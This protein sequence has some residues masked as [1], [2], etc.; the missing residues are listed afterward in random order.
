MLALNLLISFAILLQVIALAIS[1]RLMRITK[2][3][4][5]WILFSVAFLLMLVQLISELVGNFRGRGW[6]DP[7][8]I[9][10]IWLLTTMC[11][12]S[13]LF[14][15]NKLIK[16]IIVM[17][18]KRSLSQR[19]ILNT[20]IKT[21]EKERRRFS[22]DLHDG[23]GPLLSS[24]KL[25]ISALDSSIVTAQNRAIL[26]SAGEVI[27]EAIKSLKEISNNLNP[28]VLNNFGVSRA[29][30]SFI[31]KLVLPSQIKISFTSDL[32]NER[33]DSGI[34]AIIYRVV[35]EL[36]NNSIKH[37][38]A[39]KIVVDLKSNGGSIEIAV[40]DNGVGFDREILDKGEAR[41]GMGLSSIISRIS[42]VKGDIL[43]DTAIGQGTKITI[44][45]GVK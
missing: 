26:K 14:V 19:R 29:L 6:I 7:S 25:S 40:S 37:S 17:E 23:L 2:F 38:K 8:V 9:T 36:V 12:T 3:N 41:T 5:A 1:L 44:K 22:N 42:S 34:E 4:S 16:H 45:I 21:E 18:K 10:W 24:A 27:D 33:Y 31:N 28:H 13:G 39:S 20:I 30:N 32:A 11:F 15:V 35:C 43:I